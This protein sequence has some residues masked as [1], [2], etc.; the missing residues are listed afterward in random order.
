MILWFHKLKNFMFSHI[1]LHPF[2]TADSTLSAFGPHQCSPDAKMGDRPYGHPKQ[3]HSC[4]IVLSKP[5]Q[6]AQTSKN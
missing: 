6:S 4:G 1:N 3:S 5:C 2:L